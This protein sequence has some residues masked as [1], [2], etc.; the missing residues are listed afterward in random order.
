MANIDKKEDI[1]KMLDLLEQKTNKQEWAKTF[2]NI[3]RRFIEKYGDKW[4]KQCEVELELEEI[5]LFQSDYTEIKYL[6]IFRDLLSTLLN[7][8]ITLPK[9]DF[10]Y[11]K[12]EINIS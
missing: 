4:E 12:F 2:I 1:L 11:I 10:I 6:R 3:Y 7:V 8:S 5:V 9:L